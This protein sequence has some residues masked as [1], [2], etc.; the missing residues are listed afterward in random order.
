MSDSLRQA[1]ASILFVLLSIGALSAQEPVNPA[2]T[3]GARAL[4]AELYELQQ[5]GLRWTGQHNFPDSLRKFTTRAEEITGVTP[6]LYGTDMSTLN[7]NTRDSVVAECIRRHRAGQKVTLMWHAGRPQDRYHY[8]QDLDVK[9]RVYT[10]QWQDLTTPGTDENSAWL[11]QV[12]HLAVYLRRLRDANVPVLWRPYHE[13]NGN[14]FWWGNRPGKEGVA[15]LWRQLY[16]RLVNEHKLHNLVWV[17]NAHVTVEGDIDKDDVALADLAKFYPGAAYVDAL[18]TDVYNG[19]YD[20]AHY[21]ALRKLAAGKPV[22]LG[23]IGVVPDDDV[24]ERQPGWTWFM[25]WPTHLTQDN[26]EKDVRRLFTDNKSIN[27]PRR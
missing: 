16:D 18:A 25:I 19:D 4:L 23:E 2:A 17:W 6:M 20:D 3:P 15:E 14:W 21:R 24:L 22:G 10:E 13:M 12:D 5:R 9:G 26:K 8:D 27:A 1:I 7:G 11:M